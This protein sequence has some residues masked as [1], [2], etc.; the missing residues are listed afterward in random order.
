MGDTSHLKLTDWPFEALFVL[1]GCCPHIWELCFQEPIH[2]SCSRKETHHKP[3]STSTFILLTWHVKNSTTSCRCEE[4]RDEKKVSESK[5]SCSL[6]VPPAVVNEIFN[7]LFLYAAFDTLRNDKNTQTC[8][9]T[10][11]FFRGFIKTDRNVNKTNLCLIEQWPMKAQDSFTW[12]TNVFI[13]AG[14]MTPVSYTFI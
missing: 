3:W 8:Q 6:F 4:G 5:R 12:K 10:P 9:L 7:L 13:N 1:R 2:P 11:D 14:T